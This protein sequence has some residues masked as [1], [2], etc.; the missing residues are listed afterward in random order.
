M[1][2]DNTLKRCSKC[3]NNKPTKE[4]HK[5]RWFAD[6]YT[7]QCKICK[8]ANPDIFHPKVICGCGKTIFKFYLTKHLKTKIHHKTLEVKELESKNLIEFI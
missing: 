4:F 8:M 7:N 1:E 2:N 5:N 3:R 6:G